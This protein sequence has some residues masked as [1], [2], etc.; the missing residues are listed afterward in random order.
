MN[1]FPNDSEFNKPEENMIAKHCWKRRKF[2]QVAF[3]SPSAM[4]SSPLNAFID[5]KLD[6]A[7]Y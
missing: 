4:F 5:E 7:Q 1:P 2:C 3:S 6:V